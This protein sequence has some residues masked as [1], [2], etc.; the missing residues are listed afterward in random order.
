[1]YTCYGSFL[2]PTVFTNYKLYRFPHGG[3][4]S[5]LHIYCVDVWR[6]LCAA[7][8]WPRCWGVCTVCKS[9]ASRV[10]QAWPRLCRALSSERLQ[11]CH[12]PQPW[13]ANLTNKDLGHL[14]A[15]TVNLLTWLWSSVW[16]KMCNILRLTFHCTLLVLSQHKQSLHLLLQKS[17]SY[18][19]YMNVEWKKCDSSQ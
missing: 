5:S 9:G 11:Q 13:L 3:S 14:H 16:S 2:P 17:A 7:P 19:E 6:R 8:C 15:S 10:A 1:M 12:P 18:K 4:L